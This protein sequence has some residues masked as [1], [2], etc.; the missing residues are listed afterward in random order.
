MVTGAE[1]IASRNPSTTASEKLERLLLGYLGCLNRYP[2][3]DTFPQN[4]VGLSVLQ[5]Q[6]AQ[7]VRSIL[8][9]MPTDYTVPAAYLARMNPRYSY[10]TYVQG[11]F[12]Q[13]FPNDLR[14]ACFLNQKLGLRIISFPQDTRA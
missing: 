9:G 6:E 3:P 12:M 1:R 13:T 8:R 4:P 14:Q 2:T 10:E 11:H 5:Y 7:V